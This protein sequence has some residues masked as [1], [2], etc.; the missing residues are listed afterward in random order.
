[1]AGGSGL[2]RGM[3]LLTHR[4]IEAM[5]PADV[6]YRVKDQR[7]FGLAVRVSPSGIKT[8]DLAFRIRGSSKTRRIS[9]GRVTDV[10]LE[11]ARER[12]GELTRAGRTGRDSIAEEQRAR[13]VVASRLTVD[14]LIVEYTRRRVVGR[15]RTAREIERRLKRA[16]GPVLHRFPDEIRRRDIRELLD[17]AADQG[18]V[19]EAEKRRQT[20]GAMFKWAISQDL[21]DVNPGIGLAPY[22]TSSLKD[23]VLS[24]EEVARLWRWLQSDVLPLAHANV[25][26]LQLLTGAR[27][28][29][30]GGMVSEEIDTA[31][32]IWT[33]PAGRSKNGRARVTPLIGSSREIVREALVER[34]SQFLFA[35]GVGNALTSS[36]IGTCLL[37]RRAKLPIARFT[38]H[39]HRRTVVTMLVEM[40]VSLDIVAA[41]VGHEAGGRETRT[42]IRHYVRTDLVHRK[43]EVLLRWNEHIKKVVDGFQL[44]NRSRAADRAQLVP[45]SVSKR[46][47]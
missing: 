22:H 3:L 21:I 32:W 14:Q 28:G 23:R 37:A 25:L 41:V 16:L 17:A 19:R 15:L 11:A 39:D 45:K 9:L 38:T 27:C 47:N 30:L 10:S 12:A 36:H 33:L 44:E 43:R 5:C 42:L 46:S 4:S 2:T 7:C 34:K 8:W 35:T 18:I 20:I 29:E 13:T 40:G 1:V 24:G 26:R 31:L 6:P